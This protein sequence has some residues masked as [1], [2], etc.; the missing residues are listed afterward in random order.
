[1]ITVLKVLKDNGELCMTRKH[2]FS[3][4]SHEALEEERA[5]LEKHYRCAIYFV[6]KEKEAQ[7]EKPG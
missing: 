3:V 1:M 4:D 6:R 2:E 7:T 5:K